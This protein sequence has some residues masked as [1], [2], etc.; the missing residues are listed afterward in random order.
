MHLIVDK[1]LAAAA[2][3]AAAPAALRTSPKTR[4]MFSLIVV[5]L[6]PS[7]SSPLFLP[8]MVESTVSKIAEDPTA[9]AAAA[10]GPPGVQAN[11]LPSTTADFVAPAK[12]YFVVK[13]W[14]MSS[15]TGIIL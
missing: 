11:A 15:Y 13:Q 8:A 5:P 10:A 4:S 9:Q 2:A 14:S 1:P 6:A 7:L 3:P 12:F